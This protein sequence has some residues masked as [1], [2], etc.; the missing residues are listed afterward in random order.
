LGI[1]IHYRG[2]TNNEWKH[3]EERVER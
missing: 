1:Q 2:L 3:I